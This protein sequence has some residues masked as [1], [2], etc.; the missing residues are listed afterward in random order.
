MRGTSLHFIWN[1]ALYKVFFCYVSVKRIFRPIHT[2]V[3]LAAPIV[4]TSLRGFH[5]A[6]S[7]RTHSAP[8]DLRISLSQPMLTET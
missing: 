7:L 1:N 8:N 5:I 4:F 3:K 6:S 2:L